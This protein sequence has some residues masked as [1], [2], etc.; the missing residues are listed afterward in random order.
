MQIYLVNFN[1]S[2]IIATGEKIIRDP[3]RGVT[4]IRVCFDGMAVRFFSHRIANQHLR[5]VYL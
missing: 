2:I 4:I 5:A 3:S 1:R